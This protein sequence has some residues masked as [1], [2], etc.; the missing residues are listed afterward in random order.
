MKKRTIPQV[1]AGYGIE[2]KSEGLYY[3][4]H[5]IGGQHFNFT[6]ATTMGSNPLYTLAIDGQTVFTRGRLDK[7]IERLKSL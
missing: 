4:G 3:Y 7:V 6:Q 2:C 1:L 5:T